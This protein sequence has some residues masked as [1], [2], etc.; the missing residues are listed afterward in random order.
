MFGSSVSSWWINW[1]VCGSWS[2]QN[3][4]FPTEVCQKSPSELSS[5]LRFGL[6]AESWSPPTIDGRA[7]WT[8]AWAT[9][10]SDNVTERATAV[11]IFSD[12]M[13]ADRSRSSW[14]ETVSTVAVIIWE[15]KKSKVKVSESG[16]EG[17]WTEQINTNVLQ[18]TFHN[19]H[20]NSNV[21]NRLVEGKIQKANQT[22]KDSVGRPGGAECAGEWEGRADPAQS[23][24]L[25]VWQHCIDLCM[26]RNI[27]TDVATDFS[28]TGTVWLGNESVDRDTEKVRVRDRRFLFW[29]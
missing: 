19:E 29:L 9:S 4:N 27:F 10:A 8:V 16:C 21:A 6:S 23:R 28:A 1:R 20:Q 18:Q 3:L 5:E 15:C 17:G 2:M 11:T 12:G 22:S 7:T 14:S 24:F 26:Y 25:H 13:I